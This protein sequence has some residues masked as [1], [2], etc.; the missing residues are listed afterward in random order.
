MDI[1]RRPKFSHQ[2]KSFVHTRRTRLFMTCGVVIL[3]IGSLLFGVFK[4]VGLQKFH[5]DT[6]QI[7]GVDQDI[8]PLLDKTAEQA[9]EGS[10]MGLFPRRSS[11]IYP[12][13]QLIS[14]IQSASPRIAHV[15]VRRDGWH[16]L[17]ISVSQKTPSALIC[18]TL[19][20]WNG[21]TLS[22]ESSDSCY[23]ADETGYMFEQSPSFSG[24]VYNRYY[25]PDILGTTTSM[26]INIGSMATSTNEFVLLQ[27]FYTAVKAS[28]INVQALLIKPGG[29]YELYVDQKVSTNIGSTSPD[30]I[31][32]IYFNNTRSFDI[33]LSNLVS[34]WERMTADATTGKGPAS[35]FEYI[36]IR[37]GSNVFYRLIK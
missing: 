18:A 22:M 24:H 16:S 32:V 37:Y 36:D 1:S 29:E 9:L 28:G 31:L 14:N 11:L 33:Q 8:I 21:N 6:V 3:L 12:M 10:Y 35:R 25:A 19:P 34:F 17:I 26:N 20:D 5:I 15:N 13:G 7:F 23:F 27:H 30:D 4:I 2:S